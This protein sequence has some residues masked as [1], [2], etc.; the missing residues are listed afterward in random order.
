MQKS[1]WKFQVRNTE[2]FY[3]FICKWIVEEC[4]HNTS[5][6]HVQK[7][8]EFV[9]QNSFAVHMNSHLHATVVKGVYVIVF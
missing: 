1:E 2:L 7:N 3:P 4:Y 8:L 6:E 9:R 5:A